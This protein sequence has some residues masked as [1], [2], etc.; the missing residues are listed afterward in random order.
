M[1]TVPA[2]RGKPRTRV[3][4]IH[5]DY[6]CGNSGVCCSSGWDIPVEPEIENRLRAALE[7]GELQRPARAAGRDPFRRVSGLPH[8]ARVVL[9]ADDAGR[10]VFLDPQRGRFCAVHRELGAHALASACRDFP[11]IVTLTPTG[12]S[13][14]LSHYC[15]TAAAHLFRDDPAVTVEV[16][17]PA[18]PPH[19]PYEGLD[20]RDSVGPLLRP[21]VMMGWEAHAR[22][23]GHAVQTL[24]R[25]D[26]EPARAIALLARQAETA[27][28]WTPERGRFDHHLER[29]LGVTPTP[30]EGMPP[31][32]EECDRAWRV[33]AQ[34]VPRGHP[35]PSPPASGAGSEALG[36]CAGAVHRWLATRAF[37]S[38]L[39]L[40][41]EGLRTT[42]MGL[43]LALAVLTAELGRG[44]AGA[45]RVAEQTVLLEA[46]R[47]ADLLLVHLADPVA[48]ARRLSGA[49]RGAGLPTPPW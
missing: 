32:S 2:F 9:R 41:G 29:C 45:E 27:R 19:W 40:Q 26:L 18:F 48:L 38:W 33:V 12:Y 36:V 39:A 42:V 31:S 22:W 10:C 7:Q 21:G 37:G 14:K 3:L 1:T 8:G 17:P 24:A 4:S 23:E 43:R 28:E 15:P 46:I 16:D 35:L 34:C 30:E 49:E 20:A 11:R 47:R 44:N 25:P 6:V 5:A 13:I